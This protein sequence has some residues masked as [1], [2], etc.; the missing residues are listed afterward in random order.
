MNV[1]IVDFS[2]EM[3]RNRESLKMLSVTR[4][5]PNG[6]E[7]RVP[8]GH[9]YGTY[10]DIKNLSSQFGVVILAIDSPCQRRQALLSSYKAGRHEPTGDAFRDY[11]IYNDLIPLLK[12]CTTISNVFYVKVPEFEADDVIASFIK[13]SNTNTKW[14]YHIYMRD[15]DILQT[16]GNYFWFDKMNGKA[17]SRNAY[18]NKTFGIEDTFDYLPVAV[19]TIKGDASDKITNALPRFPT[20]FLNRVCKAIPEGDC[21]FEAIINALIT[22]APKFNP[23]WQAKLE[24]L[25]DK[26]STLYQQLYLNYQMVCPMYIPVAEMKFKALVQSEAGTQAILSSYNIKLGKGLMSNAG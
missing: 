20:H 5:L 8:T 21:S 10:Q 13:D 9:V 16:K 18:I 23:N 6:S 12:L 2:W 22:L 3:H 24:P 4:T 1:A 17:V 25:K 15:K 11:N 14:M 7:V 26:T 19:K